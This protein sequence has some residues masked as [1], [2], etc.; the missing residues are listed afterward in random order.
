MA[1]PFQQDVTVM[2]ICMLVYIFVNKIC[3]FSI[4][5]VLLFNI[6]YKTD[7]AVNFLLHISLGD[8]IAGSGEL[9]PVLNQAG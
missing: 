6:S 4:H 5:R 3:I 2:D 1:F 9:T 8:P 7:K